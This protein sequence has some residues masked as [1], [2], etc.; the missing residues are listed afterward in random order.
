MKPLTFF[1]RPPCSEKFAGLGEALPSL[2]FAPFLAL[3][4]KNLTQGPL[5]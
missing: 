5:A 4:Y 1:P 2:E 3:P